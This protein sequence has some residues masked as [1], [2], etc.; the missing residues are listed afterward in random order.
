MEDASGTEPLPRAAPGVRW[1]RRVVFVGLIVLQLAMVVRA[2]SA[3]HKE[4]G[5]QMFPESS[6]WQAEI[7]RVTDAGERVPIEEPWSGYEWSELVQGRG[8][9]APWR[10]QHADAGVDNQLEFLGE[11]LD[12]VAANTPA[13]RETRYLEAEVTVWPNL[14]APTTLVLRSEERS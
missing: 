8:L 10:R 3:P 13:D 11:A 1:A 12:W 4:F 6:Q 2:Y 5:F 7:V 9:T 14:G